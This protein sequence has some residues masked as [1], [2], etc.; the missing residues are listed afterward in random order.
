MKSMTGYTD[1]GNRNFALADFNSDKQLADELNVFYSRFDNH[2]FTD[3]LNAL[4]DNT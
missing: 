1:K 2:D 3:K 4:K